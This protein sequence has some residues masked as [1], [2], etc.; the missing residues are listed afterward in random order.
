MDKHATASIN[1]VEALVCGL[2]GSLSM[3][4]TSLYVLYF[5]YG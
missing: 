1:S 4:I 2:W 3:L 5:L